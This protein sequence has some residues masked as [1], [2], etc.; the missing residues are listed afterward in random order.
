MYQGGYTFMRRFLFLFILLLCGCSESNNIAVS[1]LGRYGENMPIT[2][3]EVCKMLAL[4]KYNPDEIDLLERKIVFKDTNMNKWYDKYIN[5]AFTS[6][7]ISGVDNE[8]FSPDDYLSLRQAQFL[9]NK[10]SNSDKLKLKYDEGDK[11]KPISYAMW[12]EAFEKSTQ[13]AKLNLL[14]QSI[15][16]YATKEQCSKLDD[17]FIF[18]DK[19]LLK[20][21]GIDFSPYYDCQLRIISKGKEVCAIKSIE[22][23]CPVIDNATVVKSDS[24]GIEIQLNGATRFFKVENN[25]YKEG[26]K[27][28]ICF[29]KDGTYNIKYM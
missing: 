1:S 17:D 12:V 5:A 2:R 7:Y 6:G 24:K 15:V 19:G 16:I 25:A 23:D 8:H 11:D 18:T 4:S 27:V 20:T 29:M 21:D 10:V 13:N 14:T 28:K 9:I 3:A 22:N 26:D